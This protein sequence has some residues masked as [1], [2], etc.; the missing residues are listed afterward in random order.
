MIELSASRDVRIPQDVAFARASNFAHYEVL[1]LERGLHVEHLVTGSPKIGH[2]WHI[3]GRLR[4]ITLNSTAELSDFSPIDG[5]AI[6]SN[7]RGTEITFAME[8][9]ELAPQRTRVTV[10]ILAVPK[11]FRARLLIKPLQL[12]KARL[13]NQLQRALR[14]G[15]RIWEKEYQADD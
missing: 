14:R 5:L 12:A 2:K 3:S 7:H 6:T 15:T 1:A 10:D 8:F 13:Q 11:T 4:A 9:L